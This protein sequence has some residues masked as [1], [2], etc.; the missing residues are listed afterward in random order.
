[1][2][3]QFEIVDLEAKFNLMEA[4][5]SRNFGRGLHFLGHCLSKSTVPSSN[6]NAVKVESQCLGRAGGRGSIKILRKSERGH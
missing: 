3:G 6:N 4:R 1:M 2:E 5:R